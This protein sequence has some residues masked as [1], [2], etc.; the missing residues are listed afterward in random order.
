[1]VGFCFTSLTLL[2]NNDAIQFA[3]KANLALR[4]TAH[5][6]LVENGDSLSKI[7]AIQQIDL[8]TFSVQVDRLFDYGKLP[9]L[10]QESLAIQGI[11]RPYNVAVL[12]CESGAI[13]LG[14]NFMDLERKE[15][16][17]CAGRTQE[18]GCYRLKVT[19]SSESEK[20]SA[21]GNWWVIPVGSLLAGLG[22]MVWK[23][24]TKEQPVLLVQEEMAIANQPGSR[25]GNS[26]LDVSNLELKS[27]DQTFALTFREAKLLNLFVLNKNQ[28]L[29]RD[30]I[31]KSVWEDEG[32]TVGRSVDVFVSRLRKML[33]NDS[34]V[35][36]AAVHGIGYRM[37]VAS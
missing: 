25:F 7:P 20:A 30:F 12:Y 23:R 14:Y 37:E 11:A 16:V 1:M 22:F 15:G 31:L 28:V 19:F 27:G 32:V 3:E 10:L 5:L 4:R 33:Q 2:A 6:L 9:K 21:G 8:N 18:P 36:I 26:A 17:P 35:K 34:R 29:E 13:A 24:S